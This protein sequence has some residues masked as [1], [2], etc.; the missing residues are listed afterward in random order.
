M[1]NEEHRL[2]EIDEKLAKLRHLL[3]GLIPIWSQVDRKVMSLKSDIEHL[4]KQRLEVS[5][6]QLQF[7]TFDF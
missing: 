7:D 3:Q 2:R 5:Q 4:E 1:K 6:G